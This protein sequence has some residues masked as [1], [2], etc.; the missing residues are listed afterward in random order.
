MLKSSKSCTLHGTES[1]RLTNMFQYLRWQ[2]TSGL[3]IATEILILLVPIDMTWSL[4]LMAKSK[5]AVLS[6]F[7]M[8]LP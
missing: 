3:D 1:P 8:R 2:I 7:W 5:F 4:Q 6:R